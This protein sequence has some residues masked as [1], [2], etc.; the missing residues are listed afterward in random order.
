MV[1]HYPPAYFK[2]RKTHTTISISVSK[3]FKEQLDKHRGSSSYASFVKRLIEDFD[4][5][6]SRRVNAVKEEIEDN[7]RHNED[8]FRVKCSYCGKLMYFSNEDREWPEVKKELYQ[9][10]NKWNH[11]ECSKKREKEDKARSK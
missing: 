2:Y 9:A 7:V 8:N 6:V 10:L 11:I 4:S 3:E 1:K 5:E